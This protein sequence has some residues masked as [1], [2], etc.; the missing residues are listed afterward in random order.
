MPNNNKKKK[1]EREKHKIIELTNRTRKTSIEKFNSEG[2][3]TGMWQS[4]ELD[5]NEEK[6]S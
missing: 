4:E 3:C 2:S 1:R 5:E 6:F